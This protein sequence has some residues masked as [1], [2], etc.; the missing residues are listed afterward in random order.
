MVASEAMTRKES[1]G[2]KVSALGGKSCDLGRSK[3]EG[4]EKRTWNLG[5]EVVRATQYLGRRRN[6]SGGDS[7]T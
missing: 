4:R 5:R 3:G 2:F 6:Y 7:Q 1:K